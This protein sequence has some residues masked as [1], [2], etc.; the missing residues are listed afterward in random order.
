MRRK[1]MDKNMNFDIDKMMRDNHVSIQ[2]LVKNQ[3]KQNLVY[4]SGI[5]QISHELEENHKK[6]IKSAEESRKKKEQY[7]QDILN[8]LRQI[9]GNRANLTTIIK[10]IEDNNEIQGETYE[11]ITELLALAMEK[12]KKVVEIKYRSIMNKITEF[13]EDVETITKLSGFAIAIYNILSIGAK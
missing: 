8:A 4:S 7:D 10:L 1:R 5:N 13:T 11:I 12:D 9:E 2:D 6:L 3:P